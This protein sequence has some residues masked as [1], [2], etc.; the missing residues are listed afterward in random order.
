MI[1]LLYGDE[2]Y[3]IR[4]R[5]NELVA[6]TRALNV[7]TFDGDAPGFQYRDFLDAL[8]NIPLFAEKQFILFRNPPFLINKLND[9]KIENELLAYAQNPA[10]STELILYNEGCNFN[11]ALSLYKAFLKNAKCETFKL[12][13]NRSFYQNAKNM[14]KNA[15]ISI[16][17]EALDY[18]INACNGKLSSL[19]QF[20]PLLKLYGEPLNIRSITYLVNRNIEDNS[21]KLVN[22]INSKDLSLSLAILKD[23]YDSGTPPQLIIASLAFQFRYL[24]QVAYLNEEGM[25]FAQIKNQSNTK[26]DYRLQ[27]ALKIVEKQ[28]SQDLL[29]GLTALSNLDYDLKNDDDLDPLNKLEIFIIKYIKGIY[30]SN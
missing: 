21:F 5:I 26:S 14:I 2:T 12:L 6:D 22:A 15:K 23:L 8:N 25:T 30:A 10:Y 3:L 4:Q 7:E 29:G 24:F 18:L 1:Y 20:I 16:D 17:N 11:A 28:N 9:Q 19:Y 27:M 13:D